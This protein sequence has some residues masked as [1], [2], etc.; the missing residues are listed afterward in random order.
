MIINVYEHIY[1]VH[2]FSQG[3]GNCSV[4][5]TINAL[6]GGPTVSETVTHIEAKCGGVQFCNSKTLTHI[7]AN[8][9]GV[10]F[11]N[12]KTLTNIEAKCGGGWS[13]ELKTVNHDGVWHA[14]V[15]PSLEKN[16]VQKYYSFFQGGLTVPSQTPSTLTTG[17]WW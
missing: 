5:D 1:T 11:Y 9:G 4:L 8:C 12:S 2:W 6:G 3:G 13:R 7:E 17:G 16:R 10:Q 15:S 14:T